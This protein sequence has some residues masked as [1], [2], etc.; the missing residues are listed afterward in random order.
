MTVTGADCICIVEV[1]V[2]VMVTAAGVVDE[3]VVAVTDEVVVEEGVGIAL[4][5]SILLEMRRMQIISIV[6]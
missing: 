5:D 4:V 2:V 3:R 1:A 6:T